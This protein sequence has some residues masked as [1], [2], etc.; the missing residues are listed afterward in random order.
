EQGHHQQWCDRA[1]EVLQASPIPVELP[2]F[3][4]A[5]KRRSL[6]SPVL[7]SV[8]MSIGMVGAASWGMLQAQASN[9]ANVNLKGAP[10]VKDSVETQKTP[11]VVLPNSEEHLRMSY[12]LEEIRVTQIIAK[13]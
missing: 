12:Q 3:T 1:K 9:A 11:V 10:A 4:P 7:F 5:N 13:M 2:A 8:L 6:R